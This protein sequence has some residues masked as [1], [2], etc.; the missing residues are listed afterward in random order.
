MEEPLHYHERIHESSAVLD[1]YGDHV[2]LVKG[3][4]VPYIFRHVD[5]ILVRKCCIIREMLT[6]E[7]TALEGYVKYVEGE[8]GKKDAWVLIGEAYVRGVM[9]GQAATPEAKF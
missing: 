2:M 6:E 5:Q 8:V 1:G 9:E 3:G 7:R 4:H